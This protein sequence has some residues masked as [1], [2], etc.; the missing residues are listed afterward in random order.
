MRLAGLAAICSR[1]LGLRFF[2]FFTASGAEVD[3]VVVVG[4][5]VE[6]VLDDD[7]GCV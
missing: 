4:D 6:V 1:G 3:D 2:R 7:G 5:H